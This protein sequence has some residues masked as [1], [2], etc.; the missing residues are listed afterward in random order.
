MSKL[1]YN[2]F[3]IKILI[4][5]VSIMCSYIGEEPAFSVPRNLVLVNATEVS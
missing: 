5:A 4:P 1:K 3:M 2:W